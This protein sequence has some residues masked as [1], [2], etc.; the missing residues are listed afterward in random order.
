MAIKDKEARGEAGTL[1]VPMTDMELR[2]Y[3]A[4]HA[5]LGIL[6]SPSTPSQAWI[7]AEGAATAYKIADLMIQQRDARPE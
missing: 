1:P 5:L 7:S 4:A 6:S 3:F 2:D